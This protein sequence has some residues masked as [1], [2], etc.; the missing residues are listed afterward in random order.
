MDVSD[1]DDG[2]RPAQRARIGHLRVATIDQMDKPSER[3]EASTATSREAH[4]KHLLD[5]KSVK[6]WDHDEVVAT[7]AKMLTGRFVDDLHRE[8]SRYCAREFANKRTP[9][10]SQQLAMWKQVPWWTRTQSNE[11]IRLCVLMLWQ[12][13]HRLMKKNQCSSTLQRSTKNA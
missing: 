10:S 9:V 5:S 2:E 7:G 12:L 11:D 8:R 3:S 6:D 13:S 1:L 4:I